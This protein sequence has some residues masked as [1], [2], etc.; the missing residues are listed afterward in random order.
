MTSTHNQKLKW[1]PQTRDFFAK[2]PQKITRLLRS[3]R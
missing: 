3:L 1:A 2:E